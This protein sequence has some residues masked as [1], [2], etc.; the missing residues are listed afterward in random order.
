MKRATLFLSVAI[1][2]IANCQAAA[3][4]TKPLI[5]QRVDNQ[6]QR[7]QDLERLV[8]MKRQCIE[9][10]YANRLEE[11]R[12]SAAERAEKFEKSTRMVWTEFMNESK[13]VPYEDGYISRTHPTFVTDRKIY[14]LRAALSDRYFLDTTRNLLL[15]R[16]ARKLLAD[17]VGT[18][19]KDSVLWR[20]A[21]KMLTAMEEL[22]SQAARLENRRMFFVAELELWE[23]D[24]K[25]NVIKAI[26][27]IMD[28]PTK[29]K[30]PMVSAI[31]FG[32]KDPAAMVDGKLVHEGNTVNDVKVVK[33]HRD[34]IE[35]EKNGKHW[36]Q[37]IGQTTGSARTQGV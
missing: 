3:G 2:I 7:L 35:F 11:L 20:E 21:H 10:W 24:C 14:K 12:E 34:K 31:S 36:V 29:P 4:P 6:Q 37:A 1:V 25:E 9:H 17:I 5:I 13:Q 30:Y 27:D 32:R 22:Q 26:R 23:A 15:D 8:L 18:T 16:E 19:P 28:G 33:I